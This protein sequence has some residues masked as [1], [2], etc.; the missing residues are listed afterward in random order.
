MHTIL[1]R[2]TDAQVMMKNSKVKDI[3]DQ[4]KLN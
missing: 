1:D 2:M 3:S 4:M